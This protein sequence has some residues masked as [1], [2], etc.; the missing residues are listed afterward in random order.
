MNSVISSGK[1]AEELKTFIKTG[2][3]VMKNLKRCLL[4][5]LLLVGGILT[6]NFL[7]ETSLANEPITATVAYKGVH[8]NLLSW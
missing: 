2:E 1:H 5:I 4:V 8:K 7:A 6:T 3:K